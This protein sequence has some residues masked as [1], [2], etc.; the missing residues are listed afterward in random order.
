MR[1][2]A[3]PRHTLLAV[4][5]TSTMAK[6]TGKVL[7]LGCALFALVPG[8]HAQDTQTVYRTVENGVPS[9][10]DAP[11]AD[12]RDVETITLNVPAPADDPQLTE[13][14]EQMREATDRMAADRRERETQRAAL[15]EQQGAREREQAQQSP[16]VVVANSGYW[17]VYSR[18]GR[19]WLR[20]P[21]RP[22][23]QPLPYP[24]QP[25]GWAVMTGGN[26][27]LMRPIVSGRR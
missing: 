14:L 22:P 26:A 6:A 17:P 7:V 15:R 11:P 3:A 4:F 1:R 20:P 5:Y 10:S 21:Y 25:P 8:G 12:D 2:G 27:Q 19:P 9:F 24:P 23:P 18:P 16:T 13:R